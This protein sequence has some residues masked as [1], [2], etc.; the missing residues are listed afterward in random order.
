MASTAPTMSSVSPSKLHVF[1]MRTCFTRLVKGIVRPHARFR[2]EQTVI[3]SGLMDGFSTSDTVQTCWFTVSLLALE[4][5]EDIAA[6][7]SGRAARSG[8]V[9]LA[10]AP[11][12]T[13]LY[14]I[15]VPLNSK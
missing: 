2:S 14:N 4:T 6:M 12:R 11:M 9:Q 1:H 7:V 5:S 8:D 3:S 13:C 15:Y 10:S